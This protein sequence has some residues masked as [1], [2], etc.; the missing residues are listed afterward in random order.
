MI[1]SNC[2]MGAHASIQ[3]GSELHI[4]KYTDENVAI[5]GICALTS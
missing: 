3:Y 5:Y 2:I 4:K 1:V